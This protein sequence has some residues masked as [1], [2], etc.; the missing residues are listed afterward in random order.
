MMHLL[1][2]ANNTYVPHVAT[3][4]ASIF[5]NNKDILFYVHL[6]STD[7]SEQNCEK[8]TSFV[9][10]YNHTIDIKTVNLSDFDIDKSV[11]GKWGIFPSLKLYAADLFSDVDRLLYVDADMICIGSLIPIKEVDITDSY[12]AMVTDTAGAVD[13]RHRLG[14]AENAFYGCAGLVL[15]NLALWRRDGIRQRCMS[16]Y[17]APEHHDIIKMGEQDVLNVVLQGKIRELPIE[18][19]MMSTYYE[20]NGSSIPKRY[21]MTIKQHRKYAVII[22]YIGD[23]KPWYKDSRFP[24]KDYYWKYQSFTPWKGLKYGYSSEYEGRWDNI[25]KSIHMILHRLRIKSYYYGYD[26]C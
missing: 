16:Y 5:E 17:N 2:C 15:F 1:F 23:A 6:L 24:L 8:I 26:G 9:N 4:L 22:H 3:T 10:K 14:L 13:H 20:H 12:V 21:K 19:N 11:C 18:Y 7:I 25:K